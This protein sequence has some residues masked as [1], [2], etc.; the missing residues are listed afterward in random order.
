MVER[1][2]HLSASKH[3]MQQAKLKMLIFILMVNHFLLIT[4][5]WNRFVNSWMNKI[6]INKIGRDIKTKI[7]RILISLLMINFKIFWGYFYFKFK[8][9]MA[10]AQVWLLLTIQIFNLEATVMVLLEVITSLI[11][12]IKIKTIKADV[13]NI[14]KISKINTNKTTTPDINKVVNRTPNNICID[15]NNKIKWFNNSNN[16]VLCQCH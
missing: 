7:L 13:V 16:H 6:K 9:L 12:K 2:T 14:I 15:M 10:Q 5:S 1:L 4:M 8:K 3:Q 11:I